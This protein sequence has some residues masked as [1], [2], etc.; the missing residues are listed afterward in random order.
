VLT[1]GALQV[2]ASWF[3]PAFGLMRLIRFSAGALLG[4]LYGPSILRFLEGDTARLIVLGFVSVA[5][6][7]TLVSA[8]LL[9][10]HAHA[11]PARAI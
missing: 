4:H 11:R 6:V 7:G 5:V 8:A 2:D 10:R 1:C 3:L 9:W